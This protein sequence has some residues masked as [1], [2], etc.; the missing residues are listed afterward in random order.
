MRVSSS[1]PRLVPAALAALALVAPVCVACKRTPEEPAPSSI[2]RVQAAEET[3]GARSDA[4]AD[5]ATRCI[6]ATPEIA[7]PDVPKGPAP[8]CPRDPTSSGPLKTVSIGVPEAKTGAITIVAEVAKTEAQ[9]ERGLMFRTAMTE[10]HGMIFDM[11][12]HEEHPF[13]MRN[14]C[15]PLDMIWIDSDGIIVGILE[16][17]PTLNTDSRS[18]GCPSS[19]VLEMNAGWA[20]RHGVRA[21]QRLVLPAL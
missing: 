1:P 12:S 8:G 15:I 7:P 9:R 3:I 5:A 18:V 21:G 17:V 10:D 19:L 6:V 13:W 4:R 2:A 11:Q 16:N 14:T 20:R